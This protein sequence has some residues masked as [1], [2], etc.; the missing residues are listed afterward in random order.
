MAVIAVLMP[1]IA[2]LLPVRQGTRISV[3]EA[4]SGYSQSNPPERSWLDRQIS[5]LRNFSLLLVV[6]LRNTFRRKWRLVLTL[7]TLTFGGAVFIATFNVRV[8]MMDYI[9]QIIQYFVADVNVTLDRSYH[10]DEVYRKNSR[11]ARGSSQVEGWM[12]ARTELVMQDGSIGESVSL[13]AP[14]AD[15][16]LIEP[17]LVDG[18]W[19]VPGDRN[20]IA[21]SE[22]FLEEFPDLRWGIQFA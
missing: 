4:L 16:P 6:S 7:I 2:A 13:L 15:S 12:F 10:I 21:L 17:I 11:S 9:G 14:P 3:Q 8:S 22:L 1:Q 18:R 20:A 19:I 5:R